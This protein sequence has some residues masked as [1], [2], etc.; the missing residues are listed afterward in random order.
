MVNS[1]CYTK[2]HASL[3]GALGSVGSSMSLPLGV[4]IVEKR[5]GKQQSS[6]PQK[7]SVKQL[8]SV[9]QHAKKGERPY[10]EDLDL[11]AELIVIKNPG[12]SK[13]DVMITACLKQ[14]PSVSRGR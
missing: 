9:A 4:V 5:K 11:Q 13:C 7:A 12:N 2:S 3:S 6:I 1:N 14:V 8:S 10:I